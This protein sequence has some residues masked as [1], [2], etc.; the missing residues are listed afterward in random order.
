MSKQGQVQPVLKPLLK[1]CLYCLERV[2]VLIDLIHLGIAGIKNTSSYNLIT[3]WRDIITK[4]YS[5]P[6]FYSIL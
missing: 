1:H 6:R 5:N 4:I 3:N 2:L